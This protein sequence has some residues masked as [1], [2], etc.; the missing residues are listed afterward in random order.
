MHPMLDNFTGTVGTHGR[1]ALR[2]LILVMWEAQVDTTGVDVNAG[3]EDV[4]AHGA[5]LGVPA[6]K[7]TTPGGVPDQL[8]AGFSGVLPQ[9]PIS[10]E[11]LRGIDLRGES[12]AGSQ[13]CKS[14]A[15]QRSVVGDTGGIEKH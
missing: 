2:P 11:S 4:Q 10:M 12:M 3:P 6:R 14:V 8:S 13:V 15:A 5:A 9:R 1:I 7:T